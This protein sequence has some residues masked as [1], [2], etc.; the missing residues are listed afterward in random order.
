VAPKFFLFYEFNKTTS[1]FDWP[2]KKKKKKKTPQSLKTCKF[3]CEDV[4]VPPF[5]PSLYVMMRREELWANHMEP[6]C[7]AIGNT[8]GQCIEKLGNV[9]GGTHENTLGAR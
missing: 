3:R 2:N 6:K 7:G 4:V 5:A 9:I 1:H 8:L